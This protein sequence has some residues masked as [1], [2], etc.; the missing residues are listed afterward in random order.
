MTRLNLQPS[1]LCSYAY[2]SLPGGQVFLCYFSSIDV[3][4]NAIQHEQTSLMFFL[5]H[6]FVCVHL[7]AFINCDLV[8][9]CLTSN[10]RLLP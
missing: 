3:K 6:S 5:W 4:F 7:Q 1:D 8:R 9:E 10:M 2:R